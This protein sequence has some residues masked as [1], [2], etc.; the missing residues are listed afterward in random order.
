MTVIIEVSGP[1]QLRPFRYRSES[2]TRVG[3][4]WFAVA[5]LH[6]PFQEFAETAYRWEWI[7]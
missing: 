6:V 4:L 1:L 2:M 5:I 3:W 7:D